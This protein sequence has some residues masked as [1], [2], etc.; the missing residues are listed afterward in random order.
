LDWFALAVAIVALV[1]MLRW[2]WGVIPVVIGAGLAG[3]LYRLV[4]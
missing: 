1:G 2:K 4:I 3:L